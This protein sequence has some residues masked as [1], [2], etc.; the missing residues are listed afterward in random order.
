MARM[1]SA[2]G[3]PKSLP[4]TGRPRLKTVEVEHPELEIEPEDPVQPPAEPV[5]GTHARKGNKLS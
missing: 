5:F 4:K 3:R 2:G 1:P